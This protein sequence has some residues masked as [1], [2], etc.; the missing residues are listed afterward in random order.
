MKAIKMKCRLEQ[1]KRSKTK[2]PKCNDVQYQIA[3]LEMDKIE[4][5]NW[6]YSLNKLNDCLSEL[7]EKNT[8]KLNEVEELI[9]IRKRAKKAH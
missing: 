4:L 1:Q 2:C 6:R 9:K 5:E 3:L 7:Y 8:E